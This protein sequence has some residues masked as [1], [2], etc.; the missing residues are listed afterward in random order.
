MSTLGETYSIQIQYLPVLLATCVGIT[1]AC[2]LTYPR[3]RGPRAGD[4]LRTRMRH[5]CA[6]HACKP[7]SPHRFLRA[8][9]ATGQVGPSECTASEQLAA[10]RAGAMHRRCPPGHKISTWLSRP[11]CGPP[12]P[13]LHGSPPAPAS[14]AAKDY[15]TAPTRRRPH[16]QSSLRRRLQGSRS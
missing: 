1:L 10:P 7:C 5:V 2:T 11:L 6:A 4:P 13:L 15:I 9:L 16:A 12:K 14:S 3:W 8:M